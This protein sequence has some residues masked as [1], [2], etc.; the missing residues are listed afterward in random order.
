MSHLIN[1][2]CHKSIREAAKSQTRNKT[3]QEDVL[4][5]PTLEIVPVQDCPGCRRFCKAGLQIYMLGHLATHVQ[6]KAEYYQCS[7][8]GLKFES[9]YYLEKHE[10]KKHRNEKCSEC[11]KKFKLVTLLQKHV[12][13]VHKTEHCNE[14]DFR[15]TNTSDLENHIYSKH[16]K[17]ICEECGMAFED[18]NALDEHFKEIH[19]K[20]KCDDCDKEFDS[21]DTLEDHKVNVHKH[22]K[23]TFKEFGGGLMMMM[24]S[25]TQEPEEELEVMRKDNSGAIENL[26]DIEEMQEVSSDTTDGNSAVENPLN[27]VSVDKLENSGG[28]EEDIKNEV[29]E[30]IRLSENQNINVF[31]AGFFM[32]YNEEPEGYNSEENDEGSRDEEIRKLSSPRGDGDEASKMSDMRK[33]SPNPEEAV[34]DAGNTSVEEPRVPDLKDCPDEI[35]EYANDDDQYSPEL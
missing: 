29:D 23:T 20:I 34:S 33:E 25:E 11:P 10:N 2:S 1:K 19:E 14:C 18:E 21:D 5:Y 31:G 26:M 35:K 6:D 9:G 17:D 7:A 13:D 22:S 8:C 3:V 24:I 15:T 28:S 30:D 12:D 32:M 16:P 27:V 4:D